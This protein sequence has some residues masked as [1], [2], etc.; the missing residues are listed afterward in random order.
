MLRIMN[1]TLY[2][3]KNRGARRKSRTPQ[4]K[5]HQS[6]YFQINCNFPRK[7]MGSSPFHVPLLAVFH[8]TIKNF[9]GARFLSIEGHTRTAR[10]RS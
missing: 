6:K 7:H 4:D 9:S 5:C 8:S 2:V 3:S 10:Q 1:N